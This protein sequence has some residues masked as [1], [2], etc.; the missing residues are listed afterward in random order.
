MSEGEGKVI[1]GTPL[2]AKATETECIGAPFRFKVHVDGEEIGYSEV[3]MKLDAGEEKGRLTLIR[4]DRADEN[5]FKTII[6]EDGVE[7]CGLRLLIRRFTFETWGIEGPSLI[8][9][10][11]RRR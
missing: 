5:D 11:C 10:G 1:Q 4:A 3:E 2:D 7:G 9:R 6:D 8:F